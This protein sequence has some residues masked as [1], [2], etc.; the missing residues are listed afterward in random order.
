MEHVDRGYEGLDDKFR[1]LGAE[2]HRVKVVGREP[3]AEIVN[4]EML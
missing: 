4:G 2:L 1:L 3:L